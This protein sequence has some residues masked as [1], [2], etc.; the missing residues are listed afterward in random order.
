M[1]P[2]RPHIILPKPAPN[3]RFSKCVLH[4]P[5]FEAIKALSQ[6]PLHFAAD[7]RPINLALFPPFILDVN[8]P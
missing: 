5:E 8:Y 3:M 2:I 4:L 1:M 6:A 7:S